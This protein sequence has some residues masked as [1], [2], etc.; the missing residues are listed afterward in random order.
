MLKLSDII[1]PE[2]GRFGG[3]Q[4][5]KDIADLA[6]RR[7]VKYS[8]HTWSTAVN[9]AALQVLAATNNG[10]VCKKWPAIVRTMMSASQANKSRRR[11]DYVSNFSGDRRGF[12]GRILKISHIFF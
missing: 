6:A 4:A 12:K 2:V 1:Q 8:P 11:S 10:L 3:I 9:M 5:C 7:H